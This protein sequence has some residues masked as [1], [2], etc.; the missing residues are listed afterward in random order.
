MRE[1]YKII[2]TLDKYDVH[3][4]SSLRKIFA[5]PNEEQDCLRSP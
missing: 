4:L 3:E 1:S 5:D 2:Q